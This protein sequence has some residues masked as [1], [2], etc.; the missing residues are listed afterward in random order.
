MSSSTLLFL[1][2]IDEKIKKEKGRN[3]KVRFFNLL[4]FTWNY[5]VF[6]FATVFVNEP[7]RPM[8]GNAIEHGVVDV[9]NIILVKPQLQRIVAI[10]RS[11]EK[12]LD[13][14]TIPGFV[15]DFVVTL[16]HHEKNKYVYG[17]S[18]R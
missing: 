9:Q 11:I 6:L 15:F 14:K 13:V 10:F 8:T 18:F 12:S 4:V 17:I 3:S 16:N 5:A 2:L 1:R 7:G